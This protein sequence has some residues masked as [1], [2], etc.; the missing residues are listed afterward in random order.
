MFS[1]SLA[2]LALAVAPVFATVFVTS[3]VASTT[4]H[5]GQPATITWQDSG[6]PP[7]LQDFGNAKISIYVGNAQQQ[8]SLQTIV[9]S[10]NV[11][12]TSSVQFTPDANIGPNGNEYFIR[13]ESLTAKD[14]LNPQFPALSFSAKF[15]LDNMKGTFSPEVQAQIAG[16]STAPLAGG[17]TTPATPAASPAPAST[18]G[19]SA[20]LTTSRASSAAGSATSKAAA[21]AS[22]SKSASAALGVEAGWVG[23]L[24]SALVGFTA[25]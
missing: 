9:P 25:F 6:S 19:A 2:V 18:T 22:P 13:I 24:L 11:A 7:T 15:T 23:I 10:V 21:S 8:T 16:Q 20:S 17:Q 4:F 3:P 1:Q 12:T 14:T 5:G